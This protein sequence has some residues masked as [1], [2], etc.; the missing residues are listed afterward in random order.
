MPYRTIDT[1]HQPCCHPS[2]AQ[3]VRHNALRDH[4]PHHDFQLH[5]LQMCVPDMARV[6]QTGAR[7][8][9]PKRV[10]ACGHERDHESIYVVQFVPVCESGVPKLLLVFQDGFGLPQAFEQEQEEQER[11]RER[12]IRRTR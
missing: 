5:R 8:A 12:A 9:V 11:P 10:H 4:R 7:G 1:L 2:H 3:E 6:L